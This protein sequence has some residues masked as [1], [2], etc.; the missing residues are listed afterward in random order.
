MALAK[1]G[2]GPKAIGRQVG[3]TRQTVARWLKAATFP[4]RSSSVPRPMMIRPYELYLRERW[5]AGCQNGRELWRERQTKGFRGGHETLR[6]LLVTWRTER[7]RGGPPR[8]PPMA[9]LSV[10]R[11]PPQKATRSWS[12]R[13]ARWLLLKA[14]DALKP[15]QQAY[16]Q[17]LGQLC[18]DVMLAQRLI[19]EFIQLVRKRDDTALAPWLVAAETSGLPELREFAKGIVRDRAAVEAALRYRWS[20]GITEGH[21]NRLKLI[22]PTAYRRASFALLRQRVLAQV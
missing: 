8:K 6:R 13:Q 7:G 15:E 5:E 14:E 3:W 18:P 9:T 1:Q 19:V 16:I 21:V 17:Q 10:R 11:S 22:K 4:E 2:L 12:P 20:N